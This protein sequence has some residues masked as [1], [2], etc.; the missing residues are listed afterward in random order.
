[1]K[2]REL[3]MEERRKKEQ[4]STCWKRARL[5]RVLSLLSKASADLHRSTLH[6]SDFHQHFFNLHGAGGSLEDLLVLHLVLEK[7]GDGRL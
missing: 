1:M 7:D 6:I 5:E 4:H 2:G 3:V